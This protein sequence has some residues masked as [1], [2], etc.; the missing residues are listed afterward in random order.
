MILIG[1]DG[2]NSKKKK[3]EKE[4]IA[5]QFENQRKKETLSGSYI[6]K[7]ETISDRLF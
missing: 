3:K 2:A 1:V 6:I 5:L 7:E 4:K